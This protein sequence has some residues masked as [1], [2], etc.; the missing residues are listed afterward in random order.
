MAILNLQRK[1][2][3]VGRIRLGEKGDRGQPKKLSTFRFTSAS[4]SLLGHLA[5]LYGGKVEPWNDAPDA[6]YFQL[7]S[8]ASEIDVVIPA[9]PSAVSQYYELWAAGGCKRRCDGETELISG[10]ECMCEQGPDARECSIVT[11]IN[12]LLPQFGIG[13]WRLETS[14]YNAA[15][16]LPETIELVR[17]TG[18]MTLAKLRLEQRSAMVDQ[19]KKRFVVPVLEPQVSLVELMDRIDSR[20]RVLPSPVAG[21][22][23]SP[24]RRVPRPGVPGAIEPPAQVPAWGAGHTHTNG[25]GQRS[26]DK[27][28]EGKL[29]AVIDALAKRGKKSVETV[30]EKWAG[31]IGGLLPADRA[32]L[33]AHVRALDARSEAQPIRSATELRS[34]LKAMASRTVSTAELNVWIK[35]NADAM[36]GIT[37]P[38]TSTE[39]DAQIQM[40]KHRAAKGG[41]T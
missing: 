2:V 1:L 5:E 41:M 39:L 37:D 7:H 22:P 19:K 10:N 40:L 8:E 15:T 20:T 31:A 33:D 24:E 17:Q 32:Y 27:V 26:G 29:Q 4:E 21:L 9:I 13:V 25:I 16:T 28:S 34:E 14:G 11:R 38:D 23:V 3:E 18:K 6:G 30:M 36:D 12:V 35:D